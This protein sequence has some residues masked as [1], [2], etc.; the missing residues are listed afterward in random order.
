MSGRYY[1]LEVTITSAGTETRNFTAYDNKEVAYRQ[2]YKIFTAIGAG[3]KKIN[4][5]L[6]GENL[7][8]IKQEM[9]QADPEEETEE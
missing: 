5:I 3:P 9:W 1:V 7:T 2:F 4:G 6:F 8:I